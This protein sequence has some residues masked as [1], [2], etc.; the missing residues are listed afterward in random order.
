M[1]ACG[2]AARWGRAAAVAAWLLACAVRPAWAHGNTGGAPQLLDQ[3]V[4]QYFL[5]VW[6]APVP[7]AV[8]VLHVTI[9][10]HGG[11]TSG[12][13]VGAGIEVILRDK[14]GAVL[15]TA[16]AREGDVNKFLYEVDID[17][18]APGEFDVEVL[19]K[20]PLAAGSAHFALLA[21]AGSPQSALSALGWLVGLAG[22]AALVL[23]GA[24]AALRRK[25]VLHAA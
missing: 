18:T 25:P 23:A 21:E 6:A 13:V 24:V 22:L 9:A 8:G 11:P 5:S 16:L 3:S 4:G 12:V 10:L 15:A 2:N 7:A 19:V 17:L 20:E 1:L 14:T